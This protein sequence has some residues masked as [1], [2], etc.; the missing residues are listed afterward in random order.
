MK[1]GPMDMPW[2][3]RSARCIL[4]SAHPMT[5]E[6][7]LPNELLSLVLWRLVVRPALI[8][9]QRAAQAVHC[10]TVWPVWLS[11]DKSS[12]VFLSPIITLKSFS[13]EWRASQ[14]AEL[15]F[16]LEWRLCL[17]LLSPFFVSAS[18]ESQWQLVITLTTILLI[19][20]LIDLSLMTLRDNEN[21][22]LVHMY[23][24][25]CL[26]NCPKS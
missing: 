25:F 3:Q 21:W 16:L 1:S 6:I 15:F 2:R 9:T 23:C 4:V 24:L 5:R 8:K 18:S 22:V 26:I 14:L 10:C 13:I 17:I 12:W 20:W 11:K 7:R 19:N